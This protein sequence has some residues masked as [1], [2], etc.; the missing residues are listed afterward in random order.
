[1]KQRVFLMILVIMAAALI[2]TAQSGYRRGGDNNGSGN[3]DCI[4]LPQLPNEDVSEAERQ[5]LLTMREE[6]KLAR[7]VYNYLAGRWGLSVFSQIA[8]SEGKHMEAIKLLLDKYGIVDPVGEDIPGQFSRSDFQALYAELTASGDS[9]LGEALRVGAKIEDLDI[10]D[11]MKAI[12][13]SDSQD[14]LTVF[15]NLA[16][17]SRNHLRTFV[18]HLQSLQIIYVPQFISQELFDSIIN[19]D[20]ERGFY[21]SSG[22]PAGKYNGWD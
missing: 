1:M 12:A 8:I 11:L 18:S 22:Q 6:E 10:S 17:G 16:K 14:I 19:S 3:G 9:S 21:D 5:Y 15:Q 13:E 2:L 4:V 7:D 20:P